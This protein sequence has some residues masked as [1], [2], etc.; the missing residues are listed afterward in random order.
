MEIVIGNL[1]KES[2]AWRRSERA[3]A[4]KHV[5]R[6]CKQEMDKLGGRVGRR[7]AGIE[8]EEMR[9]EVKGEREKKMTGRGGGEEEECQQAI[10]LVVWGEERE[11]GESWKRGNNAGKKKS[12]GEERGGRD[13]K[14]RKVDKVEKKVERWFFTC[15]FIGGSWLSGCSMGGYWSNRT[16]NPGFESL[17]VWL[18]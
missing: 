15:I 13:Y 8:G 12:W 1:M 9:S 17:P 2:E 16:H 7:E 5:P 18:T 10:K 14:E 6:R 11:K 3:R 4:G